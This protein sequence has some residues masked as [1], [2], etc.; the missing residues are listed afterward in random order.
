MSHDLLPDE[1]LIVKVHRHWILLLMQLW[2]TLALLLAVIVLVLLIGNRVAAEYRYLAAL[3][4]LALLGINAIVAYLRWSTTSIAL[5]DQR[6]ILVQGVF[7]RSTKVIPI[8]RVQDCST[9]QNLL[10]R[11]L[12]YGSVEIDAAGASGAEVVHYL[13]GPAGF[14]DQVFQQAHH[15]RSGQAGGT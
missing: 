14:R 6:V 3:A 11:A 9:R 1:T 2:A 10:G 12:G 8:D 13:P 5:T 4:A 15:L 7:T